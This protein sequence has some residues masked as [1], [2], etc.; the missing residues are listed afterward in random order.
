MKRSAGLLDVKHLI[1]LLQVCFLELH[2]A[3]LRLAHRVMQ[4]DDHEIKLAKFGVE[5]QLLQIEFALTEH[6]KQLKKEMKKG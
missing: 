1:A 3:E 5:S 2:N 6:F 4:S